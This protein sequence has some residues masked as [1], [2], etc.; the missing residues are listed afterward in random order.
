[1]TDSHTR[2]AP[3]IIYHYF[4]DGR[5]TISIYSHA[6]YYMLKNIAQ[7]LSRKT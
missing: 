2:H 3:L 4:F 5:G 1:M 6:L 7:L